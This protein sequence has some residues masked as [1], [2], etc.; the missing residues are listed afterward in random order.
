MLLLYLHAQ[1]L[2]LIF[3]VL[4]DQQILL[5]H[6][7]WHYVHER[8]DTIHNHLLQ[9]VTDILQMGHST[10]AVLFLCLWECSCFMGCWDF[11]SLLALAFI[12][13]Q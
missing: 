12:I 8:Y 9:T 10:L 4:Y 1:L 6:A 5:P 13:K 7:S 3:K 2:C 11:L